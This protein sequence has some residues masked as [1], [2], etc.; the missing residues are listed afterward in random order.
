MKIADLTQ[1]EKAIYVGLL[2]VEQKDLLVGQLFDEDSYFN[3]IL[4]GNEPQNW[5]ISIEEIE[6]NIYPEFN[7]LQDLEMILFVPVVNPMPFN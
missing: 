6:Q 4:D 5:I 2:T 1:E 3:P 7:W